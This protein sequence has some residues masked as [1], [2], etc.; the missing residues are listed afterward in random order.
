MLPIRSLAGSR[1]VALVTEATGDHC[2]RIENELIARKEA[3][4][5]MERE[6]GPLRVITDVCL[7]SYEV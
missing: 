4:L 2:I 5:A 1:G 3:A 7:R 6:R